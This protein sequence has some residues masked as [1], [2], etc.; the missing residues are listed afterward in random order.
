MLAAIA[1]VVQSKAAQNAIEALM[2]VDRPIASIFAMFKYHLKEK[3]LG[4]NSIKNDSLKDTTAVKKTG[5]SK[6]INARQAIP[7]TVLS[8]MPFGGF[9]DICTKHF[10]KQSSVDGNND[11]CQHSERYDNCSTKRKIQLG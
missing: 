1:S 10:S 6:N 4:G 3:A 7:L 11:K 8:N 5:N 9:L 2:S